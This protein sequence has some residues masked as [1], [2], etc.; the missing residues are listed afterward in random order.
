M[1]CNDTLNILCHIA[2]DE[3]KKLFIIRKGMQ[4]K[5]MFDS[6]RYLIN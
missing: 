4:K 2:N 5:S 6:S 3:D 1:H